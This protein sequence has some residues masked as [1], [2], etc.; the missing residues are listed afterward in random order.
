M[1]IPLLLDVGGMRSI[2]LFVWNIYRGKEAWEQKKEMFGRKLSSVVKN[3]TQTE[4][5]IFPTEEVYNS[6][7]ELALCAEECGALC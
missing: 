6:Y 7:E 1:E 5:H 2:V 3:V 4:C